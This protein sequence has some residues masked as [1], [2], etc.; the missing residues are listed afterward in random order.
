[1]IALL[2]SIAPVSQSRVVNRK[3]DKA[4]DTANTKDADGS[5][6]VNVHPPAEHHGD[7]ADDKERGQTTTPAFQKRVALTPGFW[8]TESLSLFR[9]YVEPVRFRFVVLHFLD[10]L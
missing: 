3:H 6:S 1:M 9:R 10:R 4:Q 2:I 7:E 8:R 5:A